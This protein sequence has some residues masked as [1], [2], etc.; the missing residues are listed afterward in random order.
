MCEKYVL[1]YN[2]KNMSQFINIKKSIAQ[3]GGTMFLIQ[4]SYCRC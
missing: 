3:M 4:E 2:Q 1:K